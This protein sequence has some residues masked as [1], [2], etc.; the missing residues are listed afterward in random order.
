[1]KVVIIGAKGQLGSDINDLFKN[2]FDVIPLDIEDIDIG[3]SEDIKKLYDLKPDVLINTAAYHNLPDCELNK[4]IAFR[5]NGYAL[6]DLSIISNDLNAYFIHISTDYVFDGKKQKPYN[7]EDI[8]NP[9]NTYGLSKYVGEIYIRNYA[10]DWAIVRVSGLYG[11]NPC[12]MKKGK[13]F[14]D[15]I[16]SKYKEGKEL[17]IVDDQFLTPTYTY[18]VAKQLLLIVQRKINGIIH[19]TCEGETNWFDFASSVFEILGLNVSIKKRKTEIDE[20]VKRPLYSVL[21]NAVLKREGINIM[22]HWKDALKEYLTKKYII[23]GQ[24]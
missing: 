15:T 19:S 23:W 1:M 5:V 21:E 8:P 17:S 12:V 24:S 18:Y 9:L 7:E 4:D 11:M 16:I 10:K 22:P 3:N 6:K 13:N 20:F 2:Q 14:I